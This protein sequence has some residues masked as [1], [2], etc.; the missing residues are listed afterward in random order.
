MACLC[1]QFLFCVF[2]VFGR[3]KRLSVEGRKARGI[4]FMSSIIFAIS[5]SLASVFN[6][7]D[8]SIMFV[9]YIFV[10]DLN[11]IFYWIWFPSIARVLLACKELYV[12]LIMS[13]KCGSL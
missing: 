3:K 6:F 12:S 7:H 11:P 8:Y 10:S 9:T 1:H 13:S 4:N 5:I 2:S